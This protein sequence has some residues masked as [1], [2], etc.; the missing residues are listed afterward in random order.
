MKPAGDLVGNKNLKDQASGLA[1]DA[2]EMVGQGTE[3]IKQAVSHKK[4]A[5]AAYVDSLAEAIRCAGREFDSDFPIVGKY[6]RNAASQVESV[7]GSI[8][9]AGLNDLVL[10]AQ[11][12]VRRQP[13]T[14]LGIAALA[15]FAF[16]R[17]LKISADAP[18]DVSCTEGGRRKPHK[19]EMGSQSERSTT[20]FNANASAF[21]VQMALDDPSNANRSAQPVLAPGVGVVPKVESFLK[22][23]GVRRS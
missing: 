2:K 8:R 17:F 20:L 22:S 1:N 11:S 12:F 19:I 18:A 13:T 14:S 21:I 16:V 9:T 4:D 10:N 3:A 7:A 23:M 15:G 6:I 5:G